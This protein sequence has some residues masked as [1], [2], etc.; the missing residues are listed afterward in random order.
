MLE[1]CKESITSSGIDPLPIEDITIP[2][3]LDK[4]TGACAPFLKSKN[5]AIGE[6]V[7]A[8]CTCVAKNM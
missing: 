7:L 3:S 4:I 5:S 2:Y 1:A 8:L 6:L